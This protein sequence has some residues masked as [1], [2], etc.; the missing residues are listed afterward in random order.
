MLRIKV[1]QACVVALAPWKNPSW[2]EQGSGPRDDSQKE[3]HL[4]RCVQRGLGSPVRQQTGLW[5]VVKRGKQVVHQLPGY[6]GSLASLSNFP[7]TLGGTPHPSPLRQ[8]DDGV[9]HKLP[10]Q[11]SSIRLFTLVESLLDWA[12]CSLCSLRAAHVPGKRN[13]GADML[14]RINVPSEECMIHPQSVQR[15]WEI[16]GKAEVNFLPQKTIFISQFISKDRPSLLPYAFPSIALIRQ[17]IRRIMEHKH[18]VL[19]VAP[20]WRN[21]HWLSELS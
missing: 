21:H 8:H 15:I 10:G 12:Q 20:L 6:A 17:D 16:F 3:G 4:H 18:K 14:S 1:H 2:F 19:L 11:L 9:L 7:A 5:R 13:Q